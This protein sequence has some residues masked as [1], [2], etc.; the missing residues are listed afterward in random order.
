MFLTRMHLLTVVV[1]S[2]LVFPLQAQPQDIPDIRYGHKLYAEVAQLP[3]DSVG[4]NRVDLYLRISYDFMVFTRSEKGA[5][6][7]LYHAGAEISMHAR[8][9]GKTVKTYNHFASLNSASYETS[10]MRDEFLLFHQV[11]Y[12]EEG[13][14]EFLIHVTDRGST[15]ERN[16]VRTLKVKNV[17]EK[18][19]F[20]Q[21]VA[22]SMEDAP[23]GSVYSV[24]GYDGTLPFASPGLIGIAAAPDWHADWS[25]R[26]S[27]L[28]E[29]GE[30][31]DD[32]D[33]LPLQTLQPTTILRDILPQKG[34][35]RV[36]SFDIQTS[37]KTQATLVVLKLPIE[38]LDVGA[39]RL[40]VI[41]RSAEGVDS[42]VTD[43]RIYWRDMPY[44]LRDI[45]FAIDVMRYILTEDEYDRMRSGDRREMMMHFRKYWSE[46]DNTP[47]TEYNEMMTE[48]FRRVDETIDRFQTLY[49]RNGALTDRGKVYILFGP[50]EETQRFL[51]SDEPAEEI[52]YYPSLS[53]TFHFVDTKGDGDF[54]LYEE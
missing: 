17:R 9:D 42:V 22:L 41:A 39:Y 32:D 20:G 14:Y 34:N 51:T 36:R 13:D 40:T 31:I 52:W 7:S 33:A 19:T 21:P 54:Q 45:E 3:S 6:D 5:A 43:T 30:V 27:R 15:R 35:G 2:A 4:V 12:L 16:I 28:D 26:L 38:K 11:F 49:E 25:V 29:D 48:Y 37:C 46:L 50:P 23:G 10:E 24:L 8:K 44:S 18:G 53:K 47:E 1:L